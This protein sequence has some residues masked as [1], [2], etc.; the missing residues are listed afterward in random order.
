MGKGEVRNGE[1]RKEWGG[2]EG[3]GRSEEGMG[4]SEEG[5]GR[6]E[7]G[8]GRSEEGMGRSEVRRGDTRRPDIHYEGQCKVRCKGMVGGGRMW[9]DNTSLTFLIVDS[10]KVCFPHQYLQDENYT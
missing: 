7:E 3:M 9:E 10:I 6:S 2:E 8:M 5:M 1:E 4:R